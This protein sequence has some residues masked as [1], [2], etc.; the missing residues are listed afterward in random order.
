MEFQFVHR[1]R[2]LSSIICIL[3][4]LYQSRNANKHSDSGSL[5]ERPY[6]N[7]QAT[8]NKI[9]NTRCTY[10]PVP[11]VTSVLDTA[12]FL[13]LTNA[14]FIRFGDGEINLMMGRKCLFEPADAMLSKA[15]T[16]IIQTNN[17]QLMIGLEDIFSGCQRD[18]LDGMKYHYNHPIYR[19]WILT[20]ID[21]TRRF[22]STF[23][24]SP[25]VRS[26]GNFCYN[27]PLIYET[28]RNVWRNK[29]IVVVRSLFASSFKYDIYDS[30]RSQTFIYVNNSGAWSEFGRIKEEVY[31]HSKDNL[32]ILAAGPAGKVLAYDLFLNGRRALDLGH[33]GKDYNLYKTHQTTLGFF[34]D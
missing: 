27:L 30:A 19:E 8:C 15:L 25:Y 4:F 26:T 14:S 32:F 28:L 13:L 29:D 16:T 6:I 12:F 9:Q 34:D 10:Q 18:R 21:V 24:T 1:F 11:D 2:S 23:I 3:L 20:H 22:F 17:P 31:R 5:S 7:D 33:L